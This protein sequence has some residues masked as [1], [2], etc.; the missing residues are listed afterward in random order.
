[1]AKRTHQIQIGNQLNSFQDRILSKIQFTNNN[2]DD[3]YV[4]PSYW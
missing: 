1:M 3:D 4:E 2:D